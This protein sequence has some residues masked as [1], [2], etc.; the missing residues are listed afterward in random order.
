MKLHEHSVYLL[1]IPSENY[2]PGPIIAIAPKY[3]SETE[4]AY[5]V[6]SPTSVGHNIIFDQMESSETELVLRDAAREGNDGKPIFWKFEY[7]THALFATLG[8]SVSEHAATM[9]VLTDTFM[10][11]IFYLDYD[12]EWWQETPSVG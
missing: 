11:Q 10:V 1:T 4:V 5:L 7:L 8:D 3:F 9:Q 6:P 2:V 12:E